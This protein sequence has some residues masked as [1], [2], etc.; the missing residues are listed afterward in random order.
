MTDLLMS[1]LPL[2][3]ADL[4]AAKKSP[5]SDTF[6]LVFA[7]VFAAAVIFLIYVQLKRRR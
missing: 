3:A 1:D 5:V 2:G 6:D 4:L 7:G